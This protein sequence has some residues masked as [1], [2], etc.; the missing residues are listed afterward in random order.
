MKVGGKLSEGVV[1]V[2]AHNQVRKRER[3]LV[4][5]LV[6][7]DPIYFKMSE[8]RREVVDWLVENSV[9]DEKFQVGWEVVDWMIKFR[10]K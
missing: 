2:C 3:K 6:E 1:K 4:D 9:N 10:I 8:G 7:I 5:W